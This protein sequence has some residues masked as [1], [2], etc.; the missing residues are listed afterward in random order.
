MNMNPFQQQTAS[1][2]H[3]RNILGAVATVGVNE[4]VDFIRKTYGHLLGAICMFAAFTYLFLGPLMNVVGAPL[5]Q[6]ALGGSMNWLIFLGLYM[7]TSWIADKFAMSPTS[8]AV[9][10][11]G[12]ALYVLAEAIIFTPLL[13][14]ASVYGG[15]SVIPTAAIATLTIFGGLTATVFITR[16]DFSFLRAGLGVATMAAFGLIIASLFLPF[17][18]GL[19]FSVA[20]VALAGGWI[21][22]YTSRIM[23]HYHPQQY[24]AASLALFAQV[25]LLFWYVIR[26]VMELARE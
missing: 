13:F 3:D 12:L 8:R 25:A 2:G 9:Q 22:Y 11:V 14:V 7:A 20:M 26:I 21:L 10:Y 24:V 23:A 4:R 5:T 6:F 15:P 18:L 19:V 17:S 16:K 1:I